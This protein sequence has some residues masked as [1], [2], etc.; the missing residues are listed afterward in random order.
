[1]SKI[2]ADCS[3]TSVSEV[4]RPI[5]P[6]DSAAILVTFKTGRYNGLVKKMA[7]AYTD[8]PETP[9]CNLK[10]TGMVVKQ[11]EPTANVGITPHKL[12]WTI[13]NGKLMPDVD[14]LRILNKGVDDISVAILHAPEE[15]VTK[16]DIAHKIGPKDVASLILHL[17]QGPMSPALEALSITLGFI[18]QDTT[19]ITI[20]IE[21]KK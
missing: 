7:K 15:I 4:K 19:T 11:G 1:V 2:K 18:G 8:D 14:T 16:I 9:I 21:I 13:N 3:C 12:S 17:S 10:F 20:P 5:A 6:G